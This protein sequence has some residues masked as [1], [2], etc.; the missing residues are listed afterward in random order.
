VIKIS[1]TVREGETKESVR[2]SVM[3]LVRRAVDEQLKLD[4]DS[5]DYMTITISKSVDDTGY[6]VSL[7]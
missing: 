3:G 4:E 6:V 2:D 7:S 1:C 5:F